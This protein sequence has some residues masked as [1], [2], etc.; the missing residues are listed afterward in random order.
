MQILAKDTTNQPQPFT[1][2]DDDSAVICVSQWD[3]HTAANHSNAV[4]RVTGTSSYLSFPN[5][6]KSLVRLLSYTNMGYGQKL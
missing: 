2:S 5:M 1:C 6:D 3:T 4:P